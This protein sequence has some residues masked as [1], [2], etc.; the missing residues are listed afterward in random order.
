VPSETT[1]AVKA[2]TLSTP[3]VRVSLA[4]S[5]LP[6]VWGVTVAVADGRFRPTADHDW[7]TSR[8][9]RI[10]FTGPD[11]ETEAKD[12][13]EQ[14]TFALK[15][16]AQVIPLDDVDSLL[17]GVARQVGATQLSHGVGGACDFAGRRLRRNGPT[18]S[19]MIAG[20]CA[21]RSST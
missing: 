6:G 16:L 18:S 17:A 8:E 7:L 5:C 3:T 21:P 13:A 1:Q 11:A 12:A 14:L 15:P 10:L 19:M 4:Q 20:R 2:E 9:G